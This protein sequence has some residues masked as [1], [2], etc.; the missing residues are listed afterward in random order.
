MH[1]GR[2]GR[3]KPL[4]HPGGS[5]SFLGYPSG[6]GGEQTPSLVWKMSVAHSEE[7]T[8]LRVRR[9][10]LEDV[11]QKLL[12]MQQNLWNTIL[13]NGPEPWEN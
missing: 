11:L 3:R 10:T 12:S 2:R 4:T 7:H 9:T 5:L 8:D 6:T 1:E 13:G